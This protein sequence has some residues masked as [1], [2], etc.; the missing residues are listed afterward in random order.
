MQNGIIILVCSVPLTLFCFLDSKLNRVSSLTCVFREVYVESGVFR[1]YSVSL[2]VG[3]WKV[4][5]RYRKHVVPSFESR[6][7]YLFFYLCKTL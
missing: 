7:D 6:F 2:G 5:K 3:R 1:A 4:T